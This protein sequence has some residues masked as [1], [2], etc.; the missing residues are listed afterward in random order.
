MD[1]GTPVDKSVGAALVLTFFFGPIGLFYVSVVGAIVM[2]VV[3]TVAALLTL[4]L[5]LLL[6]W[7]ISMVWAAVLAGQK[8]QAYD[9]WKLGQMRGQVGGMR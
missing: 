4:G 8:H 7:P 5:A 3:G 1:I 6:I 2:I 9:V